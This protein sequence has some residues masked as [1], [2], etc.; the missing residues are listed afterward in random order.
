MFETNDQKL[1]KSL[2]SQGLLEHGGKVMILSLSDDIPAL[3]KHGVLVSASPESITLVLTETGSKANLAWI[4]CQRK[5]I[6]QSGRKIGVIKKG[7]IVMVTSP[8][9][10]D[11]P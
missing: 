11:L 3:L 5:L 1:L 7:K 8:K 4:T 2:S 9:Y 6:G 10:S